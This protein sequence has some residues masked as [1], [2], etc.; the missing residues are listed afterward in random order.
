MPRQDRFRIGKIVI[1][2]SLLLSIAVGMAVQGVTQT[3]PQKQKQP[4]GL[5]G[6]KEKAVA[7]P[8]TFIEY[9]NSYY[10]DPRIP[11]GDGGFMVRIPLTVPGTIDKAQ[12]TKVEGPG[13]GWTHECPDGTECP[14]TYRNPY[15]GIGTN[16]VYWN[17]WSNSGQDCAIYFDVYYH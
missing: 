11:A 3:T 1:V 10:T 5:G 6:T 9:K 4:A 16:R 14:A 8:M 13:C 12:V 2:T 17:G 7:S 15:D